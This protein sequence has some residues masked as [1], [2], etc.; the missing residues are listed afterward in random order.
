M[1]V[2]ISKARLG[3]VP[4]IATLV[5]RYARHGA[6][7]PRPPEDI[8]ET[9]RE[10]VVAKTDGQMVGCGSLVVLWA[11]LAEIRSLVVSPESQGQGIGRQIVDAL[12][13]EARVLQIPRVFALT[14][15]PGFFAKLGFETL[16]REALPRKIWRDCMHC[17]KFTGCDEVAFIKAL[18]PAATTASQREAAASSG[19]VDNPDTCSYLVLGDPSTVRR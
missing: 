11:D 9:V 13:A 18:P 5:D 4:A 7:L 10:W 14:R 16:P 17:T 12:L 15:K 1:N 6:V 8:Y 19:A 2:E 3:D